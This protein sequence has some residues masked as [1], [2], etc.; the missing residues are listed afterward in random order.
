M[1]GYYPN[2]QG[3]NRQP[4]QGYPYPHRPPNPVYESPIYLPQVG[5]RSQYPPQQQQPRQPW[6]QPGYYPPQQQPPPQQQQ[7]QAP[8][9]PQQPIIAAEEVYR[10]RE[11]FKDYPLLL[12]ATA[13]QFNTA[14]LQNCNIN[15]FPHQLTAVQ[16]ILDADEYI[17]HARLTTEIWLRDECGSGK[18]YAL[19]C[20]IAALKRR[21]SISGVRKVA[22]LV[23]VP[24]Q[25]LSQWQRSIKEFGAGLTQKTLETYA[26]LTALNY[27]IGVFF[28][29]DIVL[30]SIE[31]YPHIQG[32]LTQQKRILKE[33][34]VDEVDGVADFQSIDCA[35]MNGADDTLQPI[36]ESAK[37]PQNAER[38]KRVTSIR[39]IPAQYVIRVSASMDIPESVKTNHPVTVVQNDKNFIAQS[40][41]L[42]PPYKNVVRCRDI[43]IDSVLRHVLSPVQKNAMHALDY[44]SALRGFEGRGSQRITGPKDV[45]TAILLS[46][47]SQL[48]LNED[49]INGCI[50]SFPYL[51]QLDLLYGTQIQTLLKTVEGN[52]DAMEVRFA[53]AMSVELRA[54]MTDLLTHVHLH[55][56]EKFDE[57]KAEIRRIQDISFKMRSHMHDAG[58]CPGGLCKSTL[59]SNSRLYTTPCC[60]LNVCM[61]CFETQQAQNQNPSQSRCMICR[62]AVSVK[63]Y[64]LIPAKS[65]TEEPDPDTTG[66]EELIEDKK[67]ALLNIIVGRKEEL[68]EARRMALEKNSSDKNKLKRKRTEEGEEEEAEQSEEISPKPLPPV[69][70]FLVGSGFSEIFMTIEPLMNELGITTAHLESGSAKQTDEICRKFWETEEIDVL[71][72]QL[73]HVGSSVARGLNL[74]CGTDLVFFERPSKAME[75]QLRGRLQRIGRPSRLQQWEI[76]HEHE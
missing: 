7:Q 24:Q 13:P 66:S 65:L 33:V 48:E 12:T 22:T 17:M 55:I 68:K 40:L 11:K 9:P 4:P 15:L 5:Q 45:I 54:L 37:L 62:K 61:S 47:D 31:Q 58:L 34:I 42:E 67:I 25:V 70:K 75:E 8:P 73:S 69:P 52:E 23:I 38:K 19:L 29:Y 50:S 21:G 18:T 3:Y 43:Y 6:S 27:S 26:E 14:H 71:F 2:N 51:K 30:I 44:K 56:C 72:C 59:V 10:I 49:I 36:G 74:Q 16:R 60:S 64:K 53:P 35:S 46:F 28:E 20:A 39:T 41:K 57:V 1:N 32:T 76:L 63:G